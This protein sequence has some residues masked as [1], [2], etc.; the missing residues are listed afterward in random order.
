MRRFRPLA[1]A[2]TLAC[3]AS[4]CAS[5]PDPAPP[6]SRPMAMDTIRVVDTVVVR[7][8]AET[9]AQIARLQIQLLEKDQ[10]LRGLGEELAAARQE[11]VRNLAKLQSQAS[12]AEAASGLAEAEIALNQLG[13][14][15]GGRALPDFAEAQARI[16]E[17]STEFGGENFGGALYLATEAR[18]LASAAQQR[19]QAV[20]GRSLGAGETLFAVPVGLRTARRAN[21]RSGP[22]LD[23]EVLFT[24]DPD[25]ELV[26]HSYTSQWI[27]IVDAEGREGWIFNTL[28]AGQG[29]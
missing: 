22:G 17:G 3:I 25:A 8:T 20:G 23:H 4:A 5:A 18:T 1:T 29:G 19:L 24:L 2:A 9:D 6:P 13:R 16:A 21:V 14:I 7:N 10:Q 26:G 28:V 27:R 11:V 15:E 12:R